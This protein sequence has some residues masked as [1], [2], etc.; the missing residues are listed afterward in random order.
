MNATPLDER[1]T[2]AVRAILYADPVANMFPIGVF[3]R[4]GLAP[5][6]GG[7][8]WGCGDGAGGLAAVLYCGPRYSDGAASVAV[9]V[10]EESACENLGMVLSERGGAAWVVG[11]RTA[12]DALWVGLGAPPLRVR[13]DQVLMQTTT[14]TAGDAAGR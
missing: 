4:W 8:W 14:V 7:C 12:S 5:V 2:R 13:S 9:A 3:E 1:H 11:E 10:G 6:Y